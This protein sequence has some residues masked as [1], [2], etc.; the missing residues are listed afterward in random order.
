MSPTVILYPWLRPALTHCNQA[1]SERRSQWAGIFTTM[2]F[3]TR[4][5]ST[6]LCSRL[7]LENSRLDD[8]IQQF[9]FL[10]T[11][12]MPHSRHR[13]VGNMLRFKRQ[14][15]PRTQTEP[16]QFSTLRGSEASPI[17]A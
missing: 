17:S 11:A 9:R 12:L 1:E 6:E 8:T 4:T 5:T 13:L 7:G 3:L 2:Q 15:K 10:N 16:G 14:S